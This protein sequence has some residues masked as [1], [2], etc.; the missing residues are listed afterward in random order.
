MYIWTKEVI[1]DGKSKLLQYVNYTRLKKLVIRELDKRTGEPID[2]VK[3]VH[4]L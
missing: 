2:I 1:K 3:T 4:Y